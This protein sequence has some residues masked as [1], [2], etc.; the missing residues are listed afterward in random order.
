MTDKRRKARN[1]GQDKQVKAVLLWATYLLIIS[2]YV[3][4]Q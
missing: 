4:P 3:P 2:T 1:R